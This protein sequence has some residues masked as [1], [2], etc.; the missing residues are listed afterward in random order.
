MLKLVS[1]FAMDIFPSVIATIIGAYI[2]NHYINNKPPADASV[3]AAT[4]PSSDPK[5]APKSESRPVEKSADLGNIPEPGVRAKGVAEK[6]IFDKSAVEKSAEKPPEKSPEKPAEKADK[7]DSKPDKPSETASIP[8]GAPSDNRRHQ[9][10]PREKAASRTVPATVPQP[11][12]PPPEAGSAAANAAPPA[13]NA[14][15]V[16]DLARAAIE[17]LRG[18]PEPSRSQ[19]SARA[20]EPSRVVAAPGQAPTVTPP[21]Q[22]LPPPI[23]VATPPDSRP[24][25]PPAAR[26]DDAARPTPPADIPDPRPPL[27]LRADAVDAAPRPRPSVADDVLSAA[28]SVFQSV[29]PK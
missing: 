11:A 23:L 21:L 25:Y 10:A 4:V 26:G 18:A 9:P 14:P 8:P 27:D 5:K 29:L 1:K 19:E 24:L 7:S 6:S 22:P 13:E 15:D 12:P 20:T 3:T 17:R 28:K 2:V 16:N